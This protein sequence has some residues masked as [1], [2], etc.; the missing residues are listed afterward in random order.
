MEIKKS[1]L[2]V[3]SKR[4]TSE[5]GNTVGWV[6]KYHG[7]EYGDYVVIEEDLTDK[8]LEECAEIFTDQANDSIL[9]L[10]A[11][12]WFDG[13]E[14]DWHTFAMMN[15]KLKDESMIEI[16]TREGAEKS[17]EK[18]K[19]VE[20]RLLGNKINACPQAERCIMHNDG[21]ECLST[22]KESPIANSLNY[23]E[24]A[25]AI[26]L[27]YTRTL[28]E[29]LNS[30]LSPVASKNSEEKMATPK[31]SRATLSN[32]IFALADTL[33]NSNAKLRDILGSLEL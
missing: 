19:E 16:Q 20:L 9:Q 17:L 28:E 1:D 31:A 10:V 25:I 21:E 3:N 33:G 30:I 7:K 29:R 8:I 4:F 23:L 6:I 2:I 14:K 27:D 26:N 13:R 22:A 5:K 24:K 12:D 15:L 11:E 18:Y 32:S